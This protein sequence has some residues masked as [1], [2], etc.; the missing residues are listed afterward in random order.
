MTPPNAAILAYFC[1]YKIVRDPPIEPYIFHYD[2]GGA[3]NGG[4]M[5]SSSVARVLN[6]AYL[7]NKLNEKKTKKYHISRQLLY[8]FYEH[9][10]IIHIY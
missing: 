8:I 4:K 7:V 10:S 3:K 5:R 9:F 1:V 6:E 2:M